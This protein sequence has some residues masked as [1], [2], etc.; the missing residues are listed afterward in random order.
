MG[1]IIIGKIL[2]FLFGAAIAHINLIHE[3]FQLSET[4]K[5]IIKNYQ[6]R[7]YKLESEKPDITD[8]LIRKGI[9]AKSTS[10]R[11]IFTEKGEN[12]QKLLK[13]YPI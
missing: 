7:S 1:F 11:A 13:R 3:A 9:A 12:L 2:D 10:N 6:G 8:N 5:N 4:E